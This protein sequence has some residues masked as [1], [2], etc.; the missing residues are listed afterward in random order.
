MNDLFDKNK[1]LELILDE[2]YKKNVTKSQLIEGI[3]DYS[4]F[5]RMC[6]GKENIKIDIL[7]LCCIKLDISFDKIIKESKSQ[8]IKILEQYYDTFQMMRINR[9]YTDLERLYLKIIN[10]ESVKSLKKYAQIVNHILAIIEVEMKSNSKS[11][12]KFLKKSFE[13]NGINIEKYADYNLDKEQVEILMDYS[14][15]CYLNKD[16]QWKTIFDYLINI[17]N[18]YTDEETMTFIYPKIAYNLCHI[19][20]KEQNYSLV[21]KY[22]QMGI[23]YSKRKGNYVFL[24]YLYYN[25]ALS[26]TKLNFREEMMKALQLAE[27]IFHLQNKSEEF[28]KVLES[29]YQKYFQVYYEQDKASK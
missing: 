20:L 17:E 7:V 2:S 21:Q 18:N 8:N 1:A 15:C 14:I 27:N 23:D 12:L 6:N 22:S 11:A 28:K 13:V 26:L 16:D 9:N 25:C 29:D 4:H 19:Y 10:D 5:N 3:Y 24:G